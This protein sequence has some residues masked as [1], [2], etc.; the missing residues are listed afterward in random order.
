M[1]ESEGSPIAA[2]EVALGQLTAAVD[3]LAE[4]DLTRL[5]R[6]ELL[7]LLRGLETQRRRLPVVDHALVAELDQRGVAGELAAR[8]TKTLLRDVLRLSPRQAKARYTAAVDLGPRR[9][10]TGDALPALLPAVAAAQAGGVISVEHA[11]VITRVIEQLPPTLEAVHGPAVEARLVAEAARFDPSVLARIGRHLLD[12]INPDGAEDRD[13]QHERRRHA[14]LTCRRDG[15]GELRARLTPAALAQWQAVLDPL[16]APKPSDV[17]GPD[18]R[19]PGQRM[20]DALADA[21]GLLL[22]GGELPPSGGT[23]ATVLLT[24][25]LDQLESGTGQVTTAHGGT[26]SVA[27]ALS[28]AGQATVIPVVLDST[29]ILAYGQARR[30]AT[31]GQRFALAARDQ[32]CCFPGCD[33]PPGWTQVHHVVPWA[34]GG[35]TDLDNECLLCGFHHREHEKRGWQV[36]MKYGQ[37]YWIPP[38]H[39]D[40]AQTPI[41]NTIH[42][43]LLELDAAFVP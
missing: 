15:C 29:G 1:F 25:T 8:D 36:V 43:G 20:H 41:R 24:M 11:R 3:V 2:V 35:G 13:A 37:P 5:N 31:I 38:P 23:P 42:D 32:G 17:D 40:P 18:P 26:I 10:L 30:T 21:A 33:A 6:D 27:T 9:G 39:I 34:L 14:T 19:A 12:W 4:L 28:L 16:A 7:T 22:A